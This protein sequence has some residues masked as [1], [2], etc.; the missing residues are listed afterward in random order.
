MVLRI[1]LYIQGNGETVKD[2]EEANLFGLMV[3]NMR[4]IEKEIWLM[5]KAD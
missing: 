1:M 2:V 5:E 3:L 4:G